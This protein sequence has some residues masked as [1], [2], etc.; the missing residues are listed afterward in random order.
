MS[1]RS[2]VNRKADKAYFRNTASKMK[3]QNLPGNALRG[4]IRL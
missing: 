4:G 3:K 2:T 1:K